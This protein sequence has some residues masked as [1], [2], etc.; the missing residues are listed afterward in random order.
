[1]YVRDS[2]GLRYRV[3]KTDDHAHMNPETEVDSLSSARSPCPSCTSWIAARLVREY[4]S[5]VIV[6]LLVRR[7]IKEIDR[8]DR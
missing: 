6:V 3:V 8:A 2:E 4:H 5:L 7:L 1:M